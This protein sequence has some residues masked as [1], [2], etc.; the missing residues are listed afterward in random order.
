[1]RVR[2][3]IAATVGLVLLP[4]SGGAAAT[5]SHL[6]IA[7]CGANA[8]V[9]CGSIQV[10]LYWSRPA[11]GRPLTVRFRV[12]RHTDSAARPAEPLVAFEGGPGYPSIGSAGSY[13]FM[14]GRLHRSHDLIVMDQRGTGTSSVIDCPALQNGVGSYEDAAG[15]CARQLGA[16]A[17]AYGSAA[18]ADDMAAILHGLGVPRVDLYGDSYGTYAAQAFA[19]HHPAMV[20]AAVLDGTFDQSFNPLE[21]EQSTSLRHAWRA[22]CRRSGACSGI[23]RSIAAFDRR[24]AAHPL[25]GH[26][27]DQ[28]GYPVAFRV[29]PAVFAQ[30]VGDATYS[31]SFFRD[32]PGA[33]HA[34]RQGDQVPLRRLAAEDASFDASGGSPADY[35]VGDQAAV[36]CHDFPSVWGASASPAQRRVQLARAIARL[37]RAV[38]APFSKR[39]WLASLYQ[40]QLVYGCL[41]WPAPSVPD[42]AFPAGPRPHIPVLVLDG[43]YDQATPVA[44]ARRTAAHWPDS[45]YVEV[46]NTAHISALADFQGCASG[47]VRRFL[48]TLSAGDRSCARH[49]PAV[50]VADFPATLGA[51]PA[52][53]RMPG[54]RSSAAARRAVW[55]AAATIGDAYTRWYNLM[56]G[57]VGHGLRGGRYT[58]AGPYYSMRPVHIR[59]TGDR[60]V[61]GLAVSGTSTWTRTAHRMRGTLVLAG[62]RAASGR[63]VLEIPTGRSGARATAVGMLGGRPVHLSLPTPWTPEG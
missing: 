1:M 4:A 35:S 61:A 60:F 63:I 23:L 54:D 13:L 47:I 3:L 32:L 21:P 44:D 59:F 34:Y 53:G 37:P 38:Y 51:A 57:S 49:A 50:E 39:V 30:L 14:I 16:R 56:Y 22:V 55:V 10:P 31:Y 29:T 20:R 42:P 41:Q 45:T 18:V 17:G 62:P 11:M 46:R 7:P 28:D 33:L 5:A 25:V 15:A 12:Y 6:Q 36:S 48:R 40:N 2:L 8:L 26:G 58:T 9:E 24:L 52:A 27:R 43:E 19:L